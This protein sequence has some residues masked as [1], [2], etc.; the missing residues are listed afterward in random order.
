MN[1]DEHYSNLKNIEYKEVTKSLG[2]F[3]YSI[4]FF[5]SLIIFFDNYSCEALKEAYNIG[6]PL[7]G[8][9]DTHFKY[10][11]YLNYPIVGNNKSYYSLF[12]YYNL[13]FNAILRGLQTECYKILSIS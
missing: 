5:P 4:K 6:V 8:V 2:L 1:L 12:L 3:Y 13:F 9:V 10:F 11:E 7:A